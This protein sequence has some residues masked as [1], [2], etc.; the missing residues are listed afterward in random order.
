MRLRTRMKGTTQLAWE[1]AQALSDS[2]KQSK[3]GEQKEK[4]DWKN[5]TNANSEA[6]RSYEVLEL[7]KSK[8][9]DYASPKC[10][11]GSWEMGTWKLVLRS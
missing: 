4:K 9:G 1:R 7:E 11:D 8:V 6:R 2:P 3:K 5:T 10:V